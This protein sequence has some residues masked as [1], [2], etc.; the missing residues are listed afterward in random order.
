MSTTRRTF[1]TDSFALLAA[2]LVA[3]A[4]QAERV[5]RPRLL[6]PGGPP[7]PG[8]RWPISGRGHR[9]LI[10]ALRELGYVEG[11]NLMVERRYAE[12]KN[13]R[14]PGLARELVRIPVDVIV[15]VSTAVEAPRDATKTIPIVIGFA[16]DPVGRGFVA[17]LAR[18]GG[19]ITGV[20]PIRRG[21]KSVRSGWSCSRKP[22]R[23]RLESRA[24]PEETPPLRFDGGPGPSTVKNTMAPTVYGRKSPLASDG[25][26]PEA[27]TRATLSAGGGISLI[28]QTHADD[29]LRPC[30]VV[31]THIRQNPT[32][33]GSSAVFTIGA[34]T[35]RPSPGRLSRRPCAKDRRREWEGPHHHE[36]N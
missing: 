1:L 9:Q 34:D 28:D 5:Y 29:H 7:P 4:Q 6:G 31:T 22:C 2:T 3:E 33:H 26:M 18:P 36:L 14:L 24:S 32:E 23:E 30:P 25:D 16:S 8:S 13:D 21:R 35:S 20:T 17:S 27:K 10:E 15:A 11:R 19:N 12:G